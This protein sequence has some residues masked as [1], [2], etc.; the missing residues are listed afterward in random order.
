MKNR[1]AQLAILGTIAFLIAAL[2]LPGLAQAAGKRA[3]VTPAVAT[4]TPDQAVAEARRF[5]ARNDAARFESAANQVGSDHPLA[6]YIDFWRLRMYLRQQESAQVPST[7][8]IDR[9]V[10]RFLG[11]HEGTVVADMMRRDWLLDLGK[12]RNWELFDTQYEAW[13]LRDDEQVQCYHWLGRLE[14]NRP[15]PGAAD[16][17]AAPRNLGD[18]C[19]DLLAT[20]HAAGR[21]DKAALRARLRAGLE[22]DSRDSVERAAVL[23]GLDA[24]ALDDAWTKPLVTLARG[25]RGEQALIALSR[26]ARNNPQETARWLEDGRSQLKGGDLAFAWSQVAAAGMRRLAPESFDWTRRALDATAGD[27]TL[28]WMARAA[29]REQDWPVL[30]KIIARMSESGRS[31]P[32][33]SYWHARALLAEGKTEPGRQQLQHLA[34]AP[35]FY[36]QLAAEELGELVRT[37]PRATRASDDEIAAT[38]RNPGFVRALRFYEIGLRLEGNREWNYQLRGMNDRQ[39]LAAA[40]FAC[41]QAVLDR[42]VNTAD[43]TR[44]EHDFSLRF[45]APFLA[46]L[47]PVAA[48]RSLDPAWVYGLIRQESR[49]I[50][51]ARSSAG[52]QGLMQIM[53]ATGRWIAGKL[54]VERFRVAQLNELQTNLEFGTFYLRTVLDRLDGSPVLASAAYNAGPRRPLNWRAALPAPVEGAI[55]AEIIPFSETRDYEKKVLSNAVN[56]AEMFTGQPQSL[57][58]WL[59]TIAPSQA[60]DSDIP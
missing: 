9:Q 36:G 49:F 45:V 56:Y 26:H 27:P 41:R 1:V 17:I 39:L 4:L 42:C 24:K 47:K 2:P 20:L 22:A 34:G 50:M 30:R 19:G 35:H 44:A 32:A 23:L 31:D 11:E 21:F 53:P 43:L 8:A 29:L 60:T 28:A 52:A 55:F 33:W 3:V 54:G 46:E 15:T 5:F 59:G 10:R 18:G 51:D 25:A 40:A 13:A 16:A 14:R 38:A 12:R 7:S 48:D 57:K 37:P 6:K 58:A